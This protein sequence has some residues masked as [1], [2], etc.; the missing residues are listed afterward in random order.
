MMQQSQTALANGRARLNERLAR[1]LLMAGPLAN[2]PPHRRLTNFC[3]VAWASADRASPWRSMNS[4]GQGLIRGTRNLIRIVDRKGL[5]ALA[6]GF[7]CV[8]EAE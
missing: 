4:K 5:M 8:A 3:A 6:D 2:I 1:W 7:Y